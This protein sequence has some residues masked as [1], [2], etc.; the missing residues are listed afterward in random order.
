MFQRMLERLISLVTSIAFSFRKAT[1]INW[2]LH[3]RGVQGA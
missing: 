3:R 1:Q 2:M